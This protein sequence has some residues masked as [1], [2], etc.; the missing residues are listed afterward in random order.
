MSE[1]RIGASRLWERESKNGRRYFTGYFGQMGVVGSATRRPSR[2]KVFSASGKAIS[3]RA[4]R[5]Q[6]QRRQSPRREPRR[7]EPEA[8]D[9]RTFY[10]DPVGDVGLEK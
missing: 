4:T 2:V 5:A 1:P 6:L 10:E 3:P 7:A 8:G 9:G